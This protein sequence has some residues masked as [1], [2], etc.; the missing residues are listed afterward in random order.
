M[1]LK[2]KSIV[3]IGKCTLKIISHVFQVGSVYEISGILW[4]QFYGMI[5]IFECRGVIFIGI[6][7]YISPHKIAVDRV[8]VDLQC[9]LDIRKGGYGV[10]LFKPQASTAYVSSVKIGESFQQCQISLGCPIKILD[11]L[12]CHC[13]VIE[14]PTV[15]GQQ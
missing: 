12:L 11:V 8:A 2:L 7:G 1:W 4:L 13:F 9:F 10:L 5:H 6:D 14:K 15:V 3:V